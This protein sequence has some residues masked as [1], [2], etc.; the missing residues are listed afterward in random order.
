VHFRPGEEYLVFASTDAARQLTASGCGQTIPSSMAVGDLRFLRAQGTANAKTLLF[1]SLY[2][3]NGDEH[4]TNL[5]DTEIHATGSSDSFRTLTDADGYFEFRNLPPGNYEVEPVLPDT[6]VSPVEEVKLEAGGCKAA[7]LMT[8]WNG[9][10]SG[11]VTLWNG[12]VVASANIN[13]IDLARDRGEGTVGKTDEEG[14]YE[15]EHLQPGRYT[16]WTSGLGGS[17]RRFPLSPLVVLSKCHRAFSCGC[18]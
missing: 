11:R 14:K 1:G 15:F 17:V 8:A 5:R 3:W 6:L 16:V 4:V 7:P 13:L 9:R 2:Q 18:P 12:D 10:I